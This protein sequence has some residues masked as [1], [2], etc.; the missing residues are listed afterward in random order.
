M[1]YNLQWHSVVDHGVHDRLSFLTKYVCY[2]Q[3]YGRG[4]ETNIP[5][6]SRAFTLRI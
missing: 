2:V 3:I 1:R 5:N 4:R 6:E